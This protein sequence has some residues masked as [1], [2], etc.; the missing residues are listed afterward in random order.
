VLETIGETYY[1]HRR[2]IMSERND[3]L[4]KTYKRI[5]NP[6]VGTG[7]SKTAEKKAPGQRGGKG[8]GS[9]E[10]DFKG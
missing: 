3:G 8:K 9:G 10:I 4:T 6:T 5:H 7:K 1:E 2:S